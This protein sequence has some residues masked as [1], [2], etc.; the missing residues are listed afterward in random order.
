M[1]KVHI[2]QSPNDNRAYHHLTL[3]NG[4]TVLLVKDSNAEKSAAALTVNV[5]HF[6]D[7]ADYQG[8]AHFL[9][10]MLFLGSEHFPDPGEYQQ[11]ISQHGGNHNAW[12]GTEHSHFY[13]D[14]DTPQ[15]QQA[16]ARF[17]DM[18]CRPLFTEAYVEK[19]RHAIEAEYSLKL[20]DDSRRIYQVHKETI[21]PAH[22][23]AKFSVGNLNTLN[24]KPEQTLRGALT[25]FY[26]QQYSASR[27]SLCVVSPNSLI[28]MEQWVK[29]Y[30]AAL[31][32][33][34]PA[35]APL[36]EPL[37]LADHQAILLNIR[38][39]KDSDKLVASFALPDI[40]P[41]YRHKIVSF[42]ASILGDE[43]DG[44][45]LSYLKKAGLVNQLSAGGGIDGSN[46]KDFTVSFELTKAGRADTG[47]VLRALYSALAR[48]KQQPLPEN[49]FVERQK[50]LHWSFIYQEPADALQT[51]S[52]LSVNL[53]H[54]PIEDTIF[55]DYRMELPDASLYQQLLSW[56][57]PDNMRLM[58]I[59][60][61]VPVLL[62]AKWYNT[63][64]SVT[65]LSDE[66]LQTLQNTGPDPEITLPGSNPYLTEQLNLLEK[67]QHMAVPEQ[68][69][70]T[71]HLSVWYKADTEFNTPK[72]HIFLQ[73]SLPQSISN[74]S[75][76]AT[77]R[78]WLELF[79]D[80]INQQF[81][82][83]TNA[84]LN[85]NLH[86][87][88]QG[89]SIHTSGLAAN[90]IQLLQNIL[91]QINTVT[92]SESRF[93]EIKQQL[94]RHW[95]NSSKSKPVARL[96]SQLSALLQP[97]NPEIE[98]LIEQLELL[99]FPQFCQFA[100][101]LL[102]DVHLE[103]LMVGNWTSR[104]ATDLQLMLQNWQSNQ[105]SLGSKIPA[106]TFSIK[107]TGPVWLQTETDS[108]D[109]ALVVYLAAEQANAAQ[110][111][112]FMLAN[113]LM[114]PHYFHQLRTEKQMGYL[115][116][117]GYV[118]I[119]TLPGI[120]CY[121]QSPNFGCTALYQAT[122]TFFEDF[123]Q[124]IEEMTDA[125]FIDLKQGLTA[126]LAER[127]SSLG[128]RAKRLWL[129]LGQDD[130]RFDLTNRIICALNK[131]DRQHFIELLKQL[132]ANDYDLLL[133]ASGPN[134]GIS[135]IKTMSSAELRQ[136]I[137]VA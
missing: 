77:S 95:A 81:Y 38:P 40:Q 5:G 48:I 21:N 53:Q 70:N 62:E 118:P 102:N 87:Q 36:A 12:T 84:G 113:H 63:P 15:L 39:H 56:F 42:L 25:Q 105:P 108:S 30:F 64:Y 20:K 7:P 68:I 49:L 43:S 107:G 31:P 109:H 44:S 96:F 74:N 98:V 65:K 104:N 50:L 92:F 134:E 26:Q 83:A 76:L 110:M 123:L 88:K 35:K 54:Y 116:G 34:L 111:A 17:A 117:T 135:H 22:P 115:V 59:A 41:W 131:L 101:Q 3:D 126:Q 106:E 128:S 133:L 99:S 80:H 100:A 29:Q 13:F 47:T 61:D 124:Q 9:E 24:D 23:F 112:L 58:L 10:H 14:I 27:M 55:G 52:Q 79:Q 91:L 11:F 67:N 93:N 4:L 89:I 2:K 8:M 85:Y 16:I 137:A 127:D 32:A 78:L 86:V 66:L 72:G 45:L 71:A 132:L 130:T 37:Y 129:A 75:Q 69:C 103:A 1:E 73:L 28:T 120:A 46:Y 136:K 82:T 57:R 51:A 60:P 6:D 119:N 33:E 18:F 94:C 122:V 97:L 90:Q 121:I 19:E 114:S 125:T